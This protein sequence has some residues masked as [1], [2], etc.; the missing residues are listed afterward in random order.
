MVS[1]SRAGAATVHFDG[2]A[3]EMIPSFLGLSLKRAL[4]RARRDDLEVEVRCHGFVRHQDASS[5]RYQTAGVKSKREV[6][7]LSHQTGH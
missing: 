5:N 1:P 2:S 4:E 7:T 6:R 3:G